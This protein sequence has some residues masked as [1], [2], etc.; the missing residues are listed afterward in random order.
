VQHARA[1]L[2]E[3]ERLQRSLAPRPDASGEEAFEPG[4]SVNDLLTPARERVPRRERGR[5]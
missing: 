5:R 3:L 2:D 4:V 1:A